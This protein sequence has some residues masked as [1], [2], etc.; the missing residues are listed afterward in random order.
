MGLDEL[1]IT[2]PGGHMVIH[3]DRFF[4]CSQ[5]DLKKLLKV[6]SIDWEHAEEHIKHIETH[7]Q[8]RIDLEEQIRTKSG[9]V[10][11]DLHQR[12]VDTQT[13]VETRKFPSGVTLTKEEWKHQKEF[14]K[15]LQRQEKSELKLFNTCER[16]IKKLNRCKDVM[17]GG[18][19]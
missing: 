4:P 14:L 2:T 12:V 1:N 16:N 18:I 15:Q 5:K 13:L 8:K 11:L 19:I 9:K 10:Y 6:V 7:V 3:L 17:N